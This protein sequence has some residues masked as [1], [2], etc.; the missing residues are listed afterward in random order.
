MLCTILPVVVF[1][2]ACQLPALAGTITPT[3]QVIN[4]MSEMKAKGEKMMDNEQTVYRRY[5]EWVDDKTTQLGFDIQ[6]GARKIDELIA[7]IDKAE[8]DVKDLGE[9]V[10][11]LEAE[12]QKLE[13][14]K[15]EATHVRKK[16][17][18]EYTKISEDYG[19]SV[20]ALKNAIQ[21]LSSQ[22]YDRA[23]A[24]MMLQKM[25]VVVPGMPRVLAAFLQEKGHTSLRGDGAPAVAAYEFQSG[26]IVAMLEGLYKKFKQE[27]ADVDETES[28][29][30]HAFNLLELHLSNTIAKDVSDR[31]E[32]VIVKGKRA[33]DSAKAQGELAETKKAKAADESLKAEMEATFESKTITYKENQKVRAAELEAIAKAIEIISSSAVSGSYAK[34][35]NMAQVSR[36]H[37][38]SLLQLGRS[39][40]R[41]SARQRASELLAQRARSLGSRELARVAAAAANPFGKVIGMIEDLIAKLKESAAVEAEHKAWCDEQLKANKLKRNKKNA[42]VNKLVADIEGMEASIADMGSTID[43][44]V[45]EQG[46]LAQDMQEATE[47]RS[48]EKAENLATIADAKAGFAA[49]GKALVILKEFYATQA[50]LLQQVPEMAAY[51]GQQS[52]NK[53]VVGMLEVIETDF[54]RLR[55]ETE[56]AESTAAREYDLFMKDSQASKLAKHEEEVQLRLDKDQTEYENGETKKDLSA[57][58]EELARAK[59]YFEYLKPNCLQVHVSWEER[60]AKRKEEVAALKEAYAILDQKST[61]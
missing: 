3:Q 16:Q 30:A 33:A 48:A 61:E 57:T 51:K 28:N 54:S 50:S 21:V 8:S 56:A 37:P 40:H 41:I 2:T 55:S 9:H 38:T 35:V 7:Y 31:D 6:D 44:L 58:E 39:R 36:G 53:G 23:Q 52:G 29:N 12:I 13:G 60:V 42:Q 4:M 47:L 15:A 25:S 24:E 20:D 49:V 19:E 11:Q 46:Q 5:A 43:K 14:E 34:H 26:G 27:L 1:A 45:A 32:K 17:H 18:A 10:A 22:N 59:K